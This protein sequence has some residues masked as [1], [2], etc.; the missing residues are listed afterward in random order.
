MMSQ[1]KLNQRLY[2]ASLVFMALF[3]ALTVVGCS[4]VGKIQ[5]LESPS[6]KAKV[7]APKKA[8]QGDVVSVPDGFIVRLKHVVRELEALKYQRTFS[9]K[10][11]A[12]HVFLTNDGDRVHIRVLD[13]GSNLKQTSYKRY[14]IRGLE[15]KDVLTSSP[16]AEKGAPFGI[17]LNSLTLKSLYEGGFDGGVIERTIYDTTF[18]GGVKFKP[19]TDVSGEKNKEILELISRITITCKVMV[20]GK[21]A[22]K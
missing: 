22:S 1:W 11:G 3:A 9:G 2:R 20:K 18:T 10:L 21:K 14:E 7:T 13:T 6:V 4:K 16:T 17:S 19:Q 12:V 8:Q 5:V 15:G